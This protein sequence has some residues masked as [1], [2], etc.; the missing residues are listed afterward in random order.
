MN[1]NMYDIIIDYIEN[2]KVK[3]NID[4]KDTI[5]YLKELIKQIEEEYKNIEMYNINNVEEDTLF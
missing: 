1:K 5:K 2:D 4:Y 3:Y